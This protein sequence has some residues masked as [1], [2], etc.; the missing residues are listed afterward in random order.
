MLS[1]RES[2]P[3][4]VSEQHPQF[5][6]SIIGA[7]ARGLLPHKTSANALTKLHLQILEEPRIAIKD[8]AGLL[9]PAHAA[10][11]IEIIRSVTAPWLLSSYAQFSTC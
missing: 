10:P 11:M 1:D 9:R 4:N 6:K 2:Q 5:M 3:H 8:M 7:S